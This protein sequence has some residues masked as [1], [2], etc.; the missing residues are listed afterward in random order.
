[1]LMMFLY[2]ARARARHTGTSAAQLGSQFGLI[3]TRRGQR[4]I[5]DDFRHGSL[6]RLTMFEPTIEFHWYLQPQT[7]PTACI[8][9]VLLGFIAHFRR[10]AAPQEPAS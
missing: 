3:G 1:M 8:L 5:K 10:P 7:L 2:E 4:A 6:C 9:S